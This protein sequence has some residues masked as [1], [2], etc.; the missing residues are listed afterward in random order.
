MNLLITDVTLMPT[1]ANRGTFLRLIEHQSYRHSHFPA[2][3]PSFNHEALFQTASNPSTFGPKKVLLSLLNRMYFALGYSQKKSRFLPSELL[4]LSR[5]LPPGQ[6]P[7]VRVQN[8]HFIKPLAG[9]VCPAVAKC[10][11]AFTYS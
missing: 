9:P 3:K 11:K 8:F 7:A 5:S 1:I 2:Q 4:D 10:R 6:D